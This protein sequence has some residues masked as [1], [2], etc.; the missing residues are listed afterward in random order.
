MGQD[1]V[2]RGKVA[3]IGQDDVGRGRLE[4]WDRMI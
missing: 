4:V 1:D 2:E 3:S